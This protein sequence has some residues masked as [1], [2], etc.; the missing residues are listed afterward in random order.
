MLIR[1]PQPTLQRVTEVGQAGKCIR[2]PL[3]VV[4]FDDGGFVVALRS[5]G[6]A[7]NQF[8]FI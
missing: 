6:Q 2:V 3:G 8:S 5:L 4:A 1:L 7:L